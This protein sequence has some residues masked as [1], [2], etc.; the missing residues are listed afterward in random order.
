MAC[1]TPPLKKAKCGE[2]PLPSLSP[3]PSLNSAFLNKQKRQSDTELVFICI[4]IY[5]CVCVCLSRFIKECNKLV[6]HPC[7]GARGMAAEENDCKRWW[8]TR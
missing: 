7:I 6:L 4:Y 3:I 5:M 1:H 2:M 8:F